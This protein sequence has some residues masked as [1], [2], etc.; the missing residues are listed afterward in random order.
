M[1][2]KSEVNEN[3]QLFIFRF[4]PDHYATFILDLIEEN[5]VSLLL[6]SIQRNLIEL[7]GGWLTWGASQENL[8]FLF[9]GKDALREWKNLVKDEPNKNE[10]IGLAKELL[11][12]L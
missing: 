1:I 3:R 10:S 2:R 12:E 7:D 11:G 8:D 9:N 4:A 6:T 5:K